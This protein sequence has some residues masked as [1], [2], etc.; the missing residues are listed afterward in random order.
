[1]EDYRVRIHMDNNYEVYYQ[2]EYFDDIIDEVCFVGSVSDCEAWIR[3]RE[4]GKI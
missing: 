3:L 2:R 1:M 4:A